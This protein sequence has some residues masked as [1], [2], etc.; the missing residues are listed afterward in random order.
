[1]LR[2]YRALARRRTGNPIDANLV[3]LG[4]LLRHTGGLLGPADL[5]EI[6]TS[7]ELGVIEYGFDLTADEEGAA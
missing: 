6:A 4:D 7:R 3:V 1:V 5:K 2:D